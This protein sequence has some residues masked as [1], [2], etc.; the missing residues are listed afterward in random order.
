M[1]L[2]GDQRPSFYFYQQQT[3][4]DCLTALSEILCC[5][6]LRCGLKA[7]SRGRSCACSGPAG[8]GYT[9][10]IS[11]GCWS[12]FPFAASCQ[13]DN[14]RLSQFH[15][16]PSPPGLA[17]TRVCSFTAPMAVCMYVCTYSL[18]HLSNTVK[19]LWIW[20]LNSYKKSRLTNRWRWG[21]PWRMLRGQASAYR[22]RCLSSWCPQWE[23]GTRVR[24]SIHY[25]VK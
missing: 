25:I 14:W 21:R 6:F 22:A 20:M 16:L 24:A 15:F 1:T 3:P 8:L 11:A 2:L 13:V 23:E 19:M 5:C 9:A 7:H 4:Q 10:I 17:C 12:Y 18:K